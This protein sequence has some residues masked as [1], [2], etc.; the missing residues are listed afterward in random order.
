MLDFM[1]G[2]LSGSEAFVCDIEPAIQ[3]GDDGS[4]AFGYLK[5]VRIERVI[6]VVQPQGEFTRGRDAA[7]VDVVAFS[8]G[9]NAD[10]DVYSDIA[11]VA[12]QYVVGIILVFFASGKQQDC[13]QSG[14]KQTDLFHGEAF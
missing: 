5:I 2:K 14:H 7:F 10:A 6:V 4:S 11:I 9:R 8:G 13:Q 1:R 12:D 3:I